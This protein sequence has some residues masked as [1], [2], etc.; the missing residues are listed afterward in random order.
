MS[1]G[2]GTGTSGTQPPNCVPQTD[3]TQIY[4]TDCG[5]DV[6]GTATQGTAG[7]GRWVKRNAGV[8]KGADTAVTGTV[9]DPLL[10]NTLTPS[11]S[12][13]SILPGFNIAGTLSPSAKGAKGDVHQARA[14][15]TAGSAT[16]TIA[17]TSPNYP[18]PY[19]MAATDCNST[20][21][22]GCTGT[23]DKQ[24]VV[25]GA[26]SCVQ[27][28]C[29]SG[30]PI[31]SG[32]TGT[33]NGTVTFTD[34]GANFPTAICNSSHGGN[35]TGSGD[36]SIIIQLAGNGGPGSAIGPFVT[37]VVGQNSSTSLTL[38]L[39]PAE[40]ISGTA[41]YTIIAA[42]L[43]TTIVGFTD[44]THV[45]LNANSA[46]T[47]DNTAGGDAPEE[48]AFWGTDDSTALANWATAL[49]T[50]NSTYAAS[51]FMPIIGVLDAGHWYWD[52]STLTINNS[53]ITGPKGCARVADRD[54]AGIFIP[55]DV[56]GIDMSQSKVGGL[57][58][59]LLEHSDNT[60]TLG[61]A[62]SK[63]GI[64]LGCDGSA[65]AGCSGSA[66]TFSDARVQDMVLSGWAR[67][68]AAV[69][70]NNSHFISNS[71]ASKYGTAIALLG[72]NQG[73]VLG[74]QIQGSPIGVAALQ[75]AGEIISYNRFTGCGTGYD[76]STGAIEIGATA[77]G[78][79]VS[80][81][82]AENQFQTD[83]GWDIVGLGTILSDRGLGNLFHGNTSQTEGLGFA[84]IN[85]LSA[86]V[87]TDNVITNAANGA[88]TFPSGAHSAVFDLEGGTYGAVFSGNKSH[89]I[90]SG[91]LSAGPT[92]GVYAGSSTSGILPDQT[93]TFVVSGK[94]WDLNG[95]LV[96]ERLGAG[97]VN[98]IYGGT[99]GF[100]VTACPQPSAPTVNQGTAPT[101]AATVSYYLVGKDVNGKKSA[102]SSAGTTATSFTPRTTTDFNKLTFT[103]TGGC[104]CYDVYLSDATI[105]SGGLTF[106]NTYC[107]PSDY[108]GTTNDGIVFDTGY[109]GATPTAVA[110]PTSDAAN[111][112][113][114]APRLQ[115]DVTTNASLPTCSSGTT[116]M[117]AAISDETSGDCTFGA[118]PVPTATSGVY[119]PV[120]CDGTNWRDGYH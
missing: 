100:A 34:S 75:T 50:Y 5:V 49:S 40:S 87:F 43:I 111:G 8:W 98:Q 104:A 91:P 108:F 2:C 48:Q 93:S 21:G 67:T 76:N 36:S 31:L 77:A 45:T 79:G 60:G 59:F 72:D 64:I 38:A 62:T 114:H 71:I 116:G 110:T 94:Q 103:P 70:T 88:P 102:I 46:R 57:C 33:T 106:Y 56:N 95:T 120:G 81:I 7:L 44:S 51:G 55:G 6:N 78:G 42:P 101:A 86:P 85:A 20:H 13:P 29:S 15:M 90:N 52:S 58:G 17:N 66:S 53:W 28:N 117:H 22:A 25:F 1:I 80:N 41:I 32:T 99:S 12:A 61:H 23:V 82:I 115:D 107:P 54:G 83:T 84:Y 109:P 11:G 16:L 68:I 47:F 35:C 65:T 63:S 92:D 119:C 113:I 112:A 97:G 73:E 14:K 74:N 39:A 19:P 9:T 26:G 4:C 10:L 37:T 118:T 3:G 89:N 96:P 24:V 27:S 30:S 69:K 105:N 18:Y